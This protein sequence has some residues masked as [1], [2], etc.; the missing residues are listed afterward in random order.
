MAVDATGRAEAI[1]KAADVNRK[2]LPGSEL[3]NRASRVNGMPDGR[4]PQA[5]QGKLHHKRSQRNE[6]A[7][8]NIPSAHRVPLEGEW[9]VCASSRVRDLNLDSHG[10]GVASAQALT[11]GVG[12]S[13][14]R[15]QPCGYQATAN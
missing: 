8:R 5:Q 14:H 11:S 10:R 12:Q 4:Q 2:A 7:K 6:N 9:S 13:R 1:E 3:V 15:D